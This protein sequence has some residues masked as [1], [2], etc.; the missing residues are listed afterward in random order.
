MP[1]RGPTA[2]LAAS[3]QHCRP[4]GPRSSVVE[5][6]AAAGVVMSIAVIIVDM[7]N[8]EASHEQLNQA[9]FGRIWQR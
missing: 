4:N 2:S 1:V 9:A 5:R 7:C 3:A 6:R 8:L